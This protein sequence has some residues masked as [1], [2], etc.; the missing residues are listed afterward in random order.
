[1]IEDLE[2]R[3]VS[4]ADSGL[5]YLYCDYRDH[6]EQTLPNIVGAL[7]RQLLE[8][9]SSTPSKIETLWQKSANGQ[10]PL[11]LYQA[12]DALSEVC[13]TFG[14]VFLC[15]DALDECQDLPGLLKLLCQLP[16]NV[17]IC[18]TGRKH[19]AT[20]VS[21]HFDAAEMVEIEAEDSDVRMFVEHKIEEDRQKDPDL[22]DDNLKE[23]ISDNISGLASGKFV[24]AI[25]RHAMSHLLNL[26]QFPSAG[27]SARY[28]SC[29]NNSFGTTAGFK[30]SFWQS[31]RCIWQHA[32][33]HPKPT[34]SSFGETCC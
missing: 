18:S 31:Q 23:A 27:S 9:L 29:G 21:N 22:M 6:Q 19:V 5:A 7:T 17:W 25:L 14:R 10:R 3:I 32:G 11:A 4:N 13:K 33:P 34:Q 12:L 15:I 28:R 20:V 1:M 30:G 8:K 24:L 16:S 26:P 2:N